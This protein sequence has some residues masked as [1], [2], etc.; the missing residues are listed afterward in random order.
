MLQ[1]PLAKKEKKKEGET[2]G[3]ELEKGGSVQVTQLE[4]NPFIVHSVSDGLTSLMFP[5]ML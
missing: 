4:Q 3:E 2:K 5:L 1:T